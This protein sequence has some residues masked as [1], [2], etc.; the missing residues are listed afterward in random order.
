VNDA[1][2]ERES[3]LLE[4]FRAFYREV[5]RLRELVKPGPRPAPR[6]APTAGPGPSGS[7]ARP[8]WHRLRSLLEEQAI[9]AA[10][11]GGEYGADLYR[12]AQYVMAALADEIF[13][14]LDW[15]GREAWNA[16]LLESALFGTHDAG[17]EFFRRL[18]KVIQARDPVFA[19]LGKVYLMALALGFRGKFWGADDRGALQTYRRQLFG[20]IF[21]RPTGLGDEAK[22]LFPDAYAHTLEA[23]PGRRLP[24]ARRWFLAAAAAILLVLGL[25]HLIWRST[26]RDLDRIADEILALHQRRPPAGAR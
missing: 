5:I 24:S 23:G 11:R 7:E 16:Q 26:T 10:R 21:N 17:E 8:I 22:R 6:E 15:P 19:E 18:D 9:T 4:Q 20:F 1:P 2:G 25:S 3:F 14:H 12:E 13:V